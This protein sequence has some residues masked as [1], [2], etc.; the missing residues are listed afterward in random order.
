[1]RNRGPRVTITVEDGD[2]QIQVRGH[3]PDSGVLEVL[4]SRAWS[5]WRAVKRD[6]FVGVEDAA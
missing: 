4:A 1:M 3:V 2:T 5:A 6:A